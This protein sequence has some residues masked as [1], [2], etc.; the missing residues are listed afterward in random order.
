MRMTIPVARVLAALLSEPDVD[1]YG[2]DLMRMTD[3]ASGTL[4]PV[5]HRLQAAGWLAADWE[6]VDPAS[7]GR[8]ARRYYR[9]TAEGVT[10]A[11][12]ALA[13]LRS[14]APDS[15]RVLGGADPAGA[16]AW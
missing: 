8:P 13:E 11:R 7:V 15:G 14:L 4:Y 16:P 5:L 3:L 6:S 1:R 9:L 2:L 10:A 12:R